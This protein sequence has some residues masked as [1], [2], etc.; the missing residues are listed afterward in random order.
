[1]IGAG[2]YEHLLGGRV[3]VFLLRVATLIK[4]E[5]AGKMSA[6]EVPIFI[7]PSIYRKEMFQSR[8]EEGQDGN[9]CLSGSPYVLM[10]GTV[11]GT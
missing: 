9:T 7:C 2:N 6:G 8:L 1:M 4:K 3:V 10:P 11:P 5:M